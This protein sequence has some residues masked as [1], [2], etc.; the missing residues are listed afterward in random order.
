M[1]LKNLNNIKFYIQTLCSWGSSTNQIVNLITKPSS[2]SKIFE[3]LSLLIHH[4]HEMRCTWKVKN[5]CISLS[6]LEATN[7]FGLKNWKV[8]ASSTW[9]YLGFNGLEIRSW[10]FDRVIHSYYILSKVCEIVLLINKSYYE[11]VKKDL[12]SPSPLYLLRLHYWSYIYSNV[13][14]RVC[15]SGSGSIA[16]SIKGCATNGD[17]FYFLIINTLLRSNTGKATLKVYLF[18]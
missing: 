6:L 2:S 17:P 18:F 5:I 15:V 12:P 10:N 3:T 8:V 7:F 1:I 9:N 11:Y 16:M 13:N 14:L 4:V